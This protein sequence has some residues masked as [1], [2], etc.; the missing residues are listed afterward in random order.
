MDKKPME[1]PT[2][3]VMRHDRTAWNTGDS[4]DKLK[5]MKYDLPLTPEGI[6]KA[7]SFADKISA[8][9]I[10]SITRS[11]RLRAKQSSEP[12][13]KV[14]G[15]SVVENKALNPWDNGYLAGHRRTEAESR[16]EYYIAHPKRVVP[17]GK[18]YED[19]YDA[20]TNFV[21]S[22]MAKAKKN[23][24]EARLIVTH[25]D[26]ECAITG[27]IEGEKAEAHCGSSHA[28]GSL[29]AVEYK[30]GKWGIRDMEI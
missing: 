15:V 6:K 25:S 12:L 29:M 18:P 14:T 16:I 7:K 24:E 26:V 2:I 13:G 22:E 5:G 20:V 21:S 9:D 10:A 23:P 1:H 11:D 27:F 30:G 28:P 8:L 17:D 4:E 3:L 19:F